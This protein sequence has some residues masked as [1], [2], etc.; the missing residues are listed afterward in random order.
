MR[1]FVDEEN[2]LGLYTLKITSSR[3]NCLDHIDFERKKYEIQE[4]LAEKLY[5]TNGELKE[6]IHVKWKGVFIIPGTVSNTLEYVGSS[7]FSEKWVI[8]YLMELKRF[9]KAK[10]LDAQLE[11]HKKLII[12][13]CIM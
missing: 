12:E 9:L 1:V 4:L 2:S 13:K 10:Y 6:A 8:L 11:V 5:V 3:F 7:I